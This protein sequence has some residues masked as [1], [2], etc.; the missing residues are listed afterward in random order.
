MIGPNQPPLGYGQELRKQLKKKQQMELINQTSAYN[1]QKT[2][3]G[4]LPIKKRNKKGEVIGLRRGDR[5]PKAL[6]VRGEKASL[7]RTQNFGARARE[8]MSGIEEMQTQIQQSIADQQR[9]A[10]SGP[11]SGPE[12]EA[13][14]EFKAARA[15]ASTV[16]RLDPTAYA[17]SLQGVQVPAARA[18]GGFAAAALAQLPLE[19]DAASRPQPQPAQ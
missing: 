13:M 18:L 16:Y 10:Y 9:L 8:Q 19:R 2:F 3:G 7:A 6:G 5:K 14:S 17:S 11:G 1:R 12:S 15:K 4:S